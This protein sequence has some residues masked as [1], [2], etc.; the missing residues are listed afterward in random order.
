MR[1]LIYWFSSQ[2]MSIRWGCIISESFNVS[3]GVRQGGILS[4][5]LFNIYMDDLSSRLKSHYADCKIAN[6]IINHIFYADDIFLRFP[7]HRGLQELLETCIK[8]MHY[9]SL[10]FLR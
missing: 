5:Y 4:P 8:Y 3:N 2:K 7:S 10:I 1:I 6:M 9:N